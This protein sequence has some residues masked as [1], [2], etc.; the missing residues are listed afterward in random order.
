MSIARAQMGH[1]FRL[2]GLSSVTVFTGNQRREEVRYLLS[3]RVSGSQARWSRN[4]A[5]CRGSMATEL[6]P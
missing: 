5:C 6:S 4:A 3:P 2:S 1:A